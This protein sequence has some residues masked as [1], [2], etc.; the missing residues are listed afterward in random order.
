MKRGQSREEGRGQIIY[1][2]ASQGKELGFYFT[3]G[4]K[5]LERLKEEI[6]EPNRML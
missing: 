1:S 2:F 5:P 4:R 6:T 3:C